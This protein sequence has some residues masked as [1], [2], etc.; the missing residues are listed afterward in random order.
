MLFIISHSDQIV[1]CS[2]QILICYG[3]MKMDTTRTAQARVS[4]LLNALSEQR[5]IP[6]ATYRWQFN[7][8]FTFHQAQQL[9][10][11][12]HD[13]GISDCYASPYLQARPGST[14]GYDIIDYQR[15][16]AEIG[17][18]AAHDAFIHAL[19]QHGMGLLLDI[20]PNHMGVLACHNRWW[21]DVLAHGPASRYARF[22]DINW[23]PPM[24]TLHNKV[25]L[26]ILGAPYGTV[27]E[28]GEVR[29][30]YASGRFEIRYFE[31]CLPVAPCSTAVILS[32]CLERLQ[33]QP[34]VAHGHT[35]DLQD[36]VAVVQRLPRYT[37]RQPA[38]IAER[39]R[40]ATAVEQR[41]MALYET[42]SPFRDALAQVLAAFN[43]RQDAARSF[44]DLHA[45]LE[46]QPYR[47]S[48]WRVASD[49][50][51]YRRFFDINDLA[52]LRQEDQAVFDA[53]H[54]LILELLGEGKITGLR[55]DHA[56][57]LFDPGC[58]FDTLQR[59][60]VT[61]RCRRML[62]DEND[63]SATTVEAVAD[64]MVPCGQQ[65]PVHDA[66][67]P[68]YVVVEKILEADEQ[69]PPT[70]PVHGS[71][72]YEVLNQLNR[73]FV[74]QRQAATLQTIYADFT[75]D[76]AEFADVLYAAKKLI[77]QT[78][79]RSEVI[80]LGVELGRLSERSRYWRDYTRNALTDAVR[81][82]IACFPVYRTYTRSAQ[83][84][85]SDA[86]R[87][88][89]GA[90]IDEAQ[91]RR[92]RLDPSVLACLHEVLLL[93]YPRDATAT[94]RLAQLRFVRKFQQVSGPIMAKGLEDTAFYRYTPLASVNEVGGSPAVF[95]I[96]VQAFHQHNLTRRARWPY[97]MLS[98]ATHDTKRGEDVRARLN[99]IS[100]LAQ[101]WQDCLAYWHRLN[102][103]YQTAINGQI[104]PSRQEEYFLYQTLLGVYPMRTPTPA[105]RSHLQ[106]RIQAYMRKALREAK[107]NSSWLNP[108]A[109]YEEAMDRFITAVLEPARDDPFQEDFLAFQ[110]RIA[111]LGIWNS[112]SQTLL[113]LTVPGVPDV[114]QGCELWDLNLVDPDNRRP[115]D[116]TSRQSMLSHLQQRCQ[117]SS[118]DRLALTRELLQTRRDGRIKLYITWQALT[119]RRAHS[120]MF[121]DGDYTPLAVHGSKQEHVCAFARG[122][123]DDAIVVLVP[124]LVAGLL[125]GTA[126]TPLGG[127]VWGETRVVL[128]A[129]FAAST[130]CN[131][132]T[133]ERLQP[134]QIGSASTL[135]L[136]AVFGAFP[137]AVLQRLKSRHD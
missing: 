94:G 50:I 1:I 87:A 92:S 53:T 29:L 115:V 90:A 10:P 70:W 100:E 117:A 11:Y 83:E 20:V 60:Y 24:E 73:L 37:E 22:F 32:C 21:Q 19:Q 101:Q 17:T 40:G 28:S 26:P 12:L 14:H 39:Y 63:I 41:L 51:N 42:C 65:R 46:A 43:G 34:G 54:Q 47:L 27:L 57:G 85:V 4:A 13:L 111:Q 86:D 35:I 110:R 56:D 15:L 80:N 52:G 128:P 120:E 137:V 2:D 7:A 104:V 66:S 89:I 102:Q 119:F 133:G 93:Q 33:R 103:P 49:D 44:D 6:V 106:Q 96:S 127:T 45:L 114:Y 23:Q 131:L 68:L 126:D 108:Q 84:G 38:R 81:E 121:L 132:F 9:I 71:T 5:R 58:Y 16:N 59:A 61:H 116:Y 98:T 77:M 134:Q 62:A 64:R 18:A 75:G 30:A 3:V 67:R 129:A 105:E 79:M 8:T 48:F 99:V 69:L 130:Y 25:L 136:A 74:E 107:L 55:I 91:R 88:V 118:S 135:P 122:Y 76:R 124:R 31:H 78:S 109:A 72:G 95:G 82:V 97:A 125:Q 112:L 36:L 113:K 123:G